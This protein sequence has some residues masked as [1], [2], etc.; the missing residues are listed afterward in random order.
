MQNNES[1]EQLAVFD[2]LINGLAEHAVDSQIEPAAF[3]LK[4]EQVIE[5][6]VDSKW[7]AVLARGP[8]DSIVLIHGEV[9]AKQK[10]FAFQN[11]LRPRNTNWVEAIDHPEVVV[12]PIDVSQTCWGWIV[13]LLNQ[14]NPTSVQKDVIGG[15]AEIASEFVTAQNQKQILAK[16]SFVDDVFRFSVNAHRSLDSVEVGHHLAND[17]RSLLDCER[18][19]V[20][21]MNRGVPKL[22]AVSSVATVERRSDLVQKMKSLVKR[23]SR[24]ND[25]IFS[26]QPPPDSRLAM[27]LENHISKTGLPFVFAVPIYSTDDQGQ[28]SKRNLSGYLF[29]ESTSEI[30]RFRFAHAISYVMPHA[31]SGLKNAAQHSAIP[32]RRTLTGLGKLTS[33][34]NLSRLGAVLGLLALV[35][36]ASLL[37]KTE[38]KVRINGE[39]RPVVQRNVFAPYDGIVD[40]VLVGHG[41]RVALDQRLIQIRSSDL[42]LEI[43][44]VGSDIQKLAQLKDAKRIALNQVSGA[45]A[46]PSIAAQIASDISDLE[47]QNASLVGREKFLRSERKK[48]SIHSPIVGQVMT[49][50]VQQKLTNK[51]VR[52]GDPM[53][54]IAQLDGE[55]NLVFRVPERRI[56]YILDATKV[57]TQPV[58]LEFFLESNPS[59]KFRVPI[60]EVGQSAIQDPELGAVTLVKCKLPDELL[61]KRLG[62]TVVG[63]VFCGSRSL[64]YVW[65]QEM[66]DSI[67]RRFVW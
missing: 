60:I 23:A 47:F 33:F 67:Q 65:T 32:F 19:S 5:T 39:L 26:D 11:S 29:A 6:I 48:L 9:T 36:F 31:E 43:E 56:G 15:I 13:V 24:Y 16:K 38:F 34:A 59:K 22:L 12:S 4:T 1:E 21:Q 41:D 51:P 61:P 25:S 30:D 7:T 35:V 40:S 50:Q 55:W 49:W 53:L 62:A 17:A 27:M 14:S 10:L 37:I 18:V 57:K 45:N 3:F 46:D 42:D 58:E 52:W 63:D 64:W 2:S 44:K 28:Q 66:F 54:K 20:F 8:D